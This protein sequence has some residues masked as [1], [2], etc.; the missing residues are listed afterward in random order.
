MAVCTREE[1][2]GP[3]TRARRGQDGLQPAEV[4]SCRVN[5]RFWAH[6]YQIEM[7]AL[8]LLPSIPTADTPAYSIDSGRRCHWPGYLS[9][10]RASSAAISARGI[11]R[12]GI[13]TGSIGRSSRARAFTQSRDPATGKNTPCRCQF[14]VEAAK[15]PSRRSST[16]AGELPGTLRRP[17]GPLSG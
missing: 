16:C 5:R 12:Y 3:R 8:V 13:L 9:A 14:L 2:R 7:T 6:E 4:S 10:N 1:G 11:R 17:R 15:A